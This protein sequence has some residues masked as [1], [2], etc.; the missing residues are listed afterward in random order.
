MSDKLLEKY[1]T[2]LKKIIDNQD[3][4]KELEESIEDITKEDLEQLIK[5]HN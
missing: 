3:L 1:F 5:K 2:E 4:I